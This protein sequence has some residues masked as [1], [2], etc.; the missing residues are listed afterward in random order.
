[1][2][3]TI[4]N[5]LLSS[6]LVAVLLAIVFVFTFAA[7]NEKIN[8]TQADDWADYGHDPSNNKYSDLNQVDTGN[9][10]RLKEVWHYKEEEEGGSLF[11]NPL[12]VNGRMYALMPSRKLLALEA[13]SGKLIWEFM[14]DKSSISNWSRSVTYHAGKAGEINRIFLISGGTLYA[15][16]ADN[17]KLIEDFANKGKLDFYTGLSVADS[18]RDRVH[19]TSNAPGIIYDDLFIVGCKVPDEIPS[20]S[21]DI[22]AFNL[23]TGKLEWVFHTIPKKGEFGADTWADNARERNGGANC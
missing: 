14:P 10:T 12:V 20:T 7:P 1:M 21:G 4:Q 5:L 19:V 11:F 23:Y 3:H 16:N 22:R 9:V 18:M 2:K 13:E 8:A 15:L 6:C 17:G